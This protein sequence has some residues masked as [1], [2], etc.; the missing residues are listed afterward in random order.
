MEELL[1]RGAII[2]YGID[3]CVETP[4]A[5]AAEEGRVK[6]MIKLL[7]RNANPNAISEEYGGVIN[8]AISSGNCD[9]VRLLV[10]RD[11][12]LA[13]QDEAVEKKMAAINAERAAREEAEAAHYEAHSY[14]GDNED[15]EGGDG[16]GSAGSES[17]SEDEEDDDDDDDEEEEEEEEEEVERIRSPLALA[18]L[19]SDLT[20]FNFLIE[21]YADKLPTAE[22]NTALVKAAEHGRME[23]FL[24]LYH[25]YQHPKST[26]EEALD[27]ACKE[28]QW[29]IIRLL[30][31]EYPGLDCNQAFL[32]TCHGYDAEQEIQV[33]K[34]MWEY[35]N[36]S[37][38]AQTLN[39]SLYHAT[40]YE[41][42]HTVK[43]LLEL[44]ASPNAT[45]EE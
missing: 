3:E 30:L 12:S 16:S 9:A 37:I 34:E 43:V 25:D 11:V 21:E 4:L 41:A 5:M 24:R 38:S 27:A 8:A 1:N 18:A 15:R 23:T 35:S 2:D 14:D 26:M 17:G 33:L 42:E 13:S 29:D 44:G 31:K 45:G 40:D 32:N 39:D 28:R 7:N 10:A 22:F 6:V 19:R 20:M 36:K